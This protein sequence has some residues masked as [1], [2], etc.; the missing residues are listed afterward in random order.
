MNKPEEE[1]FDVD[2]SDRIDALTTYA[3][4]YHGV[5]MSALEGLGRRHDRIDE[6][7]CAFNQRFS[8]LEKQITQL[9]I[10]ASAQAKADLRAAVLRLELWI[11]GMTFALLI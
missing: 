10:A 2:K 7:L 3:E 6:R 8:E 9:H 5:T 11:G 4:L 1:E